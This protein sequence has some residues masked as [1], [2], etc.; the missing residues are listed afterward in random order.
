MNR[1]IESLSALILAVMFCTIS[2]AQEMMPI[3]PKDEQRSHHPDQ[4]KL[5][6]IHAE[7]DQ[8][9][10]LSAE[11]KAKMESIRQESFAQHK[12]IKDELR[13]RHGAL[14]K[15]LDSDAPDRA[16]AQ[17]AADAISQTQ[18]AMLRQHIDFIFKIREIL[19]P[20]QYKKLGALRQKH[21]AERQQ[22]RKDR[23]TTPPP[24]PRN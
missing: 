19:T 18:A 15:I 21:E 13:S 10:S 20:E 11:Q 7:I 23:R 14:R 6:K 24:T 9:L 2:H 4:R 17:A 5:D 3:L 1:L 22:R 16:K 8:A 12:T